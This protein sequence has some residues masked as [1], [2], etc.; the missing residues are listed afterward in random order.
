[1]RREMKTLYVN[2]WF[3]SIFSHIVADNVLTAFSA[4]ELAEKYRGQQ[5]EAVRM[6]SAEL[7]FPV[8]ASDVTI[9]AH[10]PESEVPPDAREKIALFKRGDRY[11]FGL[12]AYFLAQ[13]K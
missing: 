1:M 5:Q 6:L 3:K 13:E 8:H 2:R 12:T 9:L 7:G 10:V 11:R 4:S